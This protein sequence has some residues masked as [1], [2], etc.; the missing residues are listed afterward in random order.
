MSSCP[1]RSPSR[2]HT[3]IS[4]DDHVLE[5]PS[6]FAGRLPRDTPTPHHRVVEGDDGGHYW[7]I[8]GQAY[9]I[10]DSNIAAG[11]AT[12]EWGGDPR[13]MRSCAGS[14]DPAAHVRDI[15]IAGIAM[16]LNFPSAIWGFAGRVFS[17]MADPT[18]GLACYFARTTI[19]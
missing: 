13:G 3:I 5:P 10:R 16:S 14:Y 15:N 12:T 6:L 2:P 4:A 8:D 18:L 19:G 11:R 17:A 7:L 1:I 9:P